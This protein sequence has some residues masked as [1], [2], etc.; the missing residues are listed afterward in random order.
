MGFNRTKCRV[1]HFGH[2]NPL[3]R[4]RLGT[5]WLESSQAER[6]LGSLTDRKLNMNQQCAQVAKKANGILACTRNSV[7]SRSRE[8]ILPL[9]S[10]LVRSH[11]GYCVQFWAPQFRKD[12]E[13]LEQVQRR[14][15]RL[16]KGLEHK[17]SEEWLRELVLFSLEKR[18]LRGDLITLYNYLKGGCSQVGISHFSQTTSNRTSRHSLKLC[19]GRF[20][21]DMRKKFLTE[22]VIGRWNGLSR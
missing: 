22:K 7:A 20:G 3:P 16:V 5:E 12:I 19:Q 21:S 14:A 9:H 13:V 11:L 1:L 2:N 10:V 4:Y 18:G 17:P 15:M 8:E 6:E